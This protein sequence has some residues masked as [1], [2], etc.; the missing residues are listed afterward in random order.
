MDDR[1]PG[2]YPDPQ[3]STGSLRYWNGS[4]WSEKKYAPEEVGSNSF[5]KVR[6][7]SSIGFPKTILALCKFLQG[8]IGTIIFLFFLLVILC[9]LFNLGGWKIAGST[10]VE[11]GSKMAMVSVA[12]AFISN[13]IL[14]PIMTIAEGRLLK[15]VLV[16]TMADADNYPN[17]Q[18]AEIISFTVFVGRIKRTERKC[19]IAGS[20]IAAALGYFIHDPLMDSIGNPAT[21]VITVLVIFLGGI[22]LSTV[23]AGR[24]SSRY[25][26]EDPIMFAEY[27]RMP[28]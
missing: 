28:F 12:C 13:I 17:D 8:L 22:I 3:G 26:R 2:W 7:S 18:A 10:L 20:L 5:E 16:E 23:I 11:W 24:A 27:S 19:L 9:S 1:Q 25:R 14:V 15:H 4:E 6:S 21:D